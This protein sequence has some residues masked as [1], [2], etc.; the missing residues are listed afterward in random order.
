MITLSRLTMIV[1]FCLSATLSVNFCESIN[2]DCDK[3][4]GVA[5][6]RADPV[7]LP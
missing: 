2:S 7:K 6:A 1:V 4:V 3:A 5:A